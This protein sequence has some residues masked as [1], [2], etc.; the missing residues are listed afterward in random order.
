MERISLIPIG[1]IGSVTKNMYLYEYGDEILIVDCGL[2]FVD[3]TVPGVDLLL[4]DISYLKQT[5]KRIV[6]MV[7]THGHEDHIGALPF[8]LP[9]LPRFPVYGSTLTA[10][11]ANEKLKDFGSSHQVVPVSFGEEIRLGS[12]SIYWIRV[13][14]SILDT[15]HFFIRTPAGNFYHGSDFKFDFTPVDGKPSQIDSIVEKAQEGIVCLLSDCLGAEREGFSPSEMSIFESFEEEFRKT[16][17]KIFVTTYSSNISRLNQAIEVGVRLGRKICFIGRSLLKA[18]DVGKTLSYMKYP[19]SDEIKPHEVS[20]Y[21]PSQ[22]LLLVA[23]SQAQEDS[24]LVRIAQGEDRDVKIEKG[25][26]VI[27]SADPIPGNEVS[28]NSLIDT[29]AKAGA[30]VVYSAITD[31]FHVSGH[32]SQ[33]DLKLMISLTRPSSLLPIGGT[34]KQMVSFADIA[35][36]MGYQDK[37]VILIDNGQEVIFERGTWRT[38]RKIHMAH[39]FVDEITGGEMEHYIIRDRMKIAKDGM[40]VIIVEVDSSNGHIVGRPDIISRGFVYPKESLFLKKLLLTLQASF[41]K[42]KDNPQNWVYYKKIIQQHAEELLWK[43][44]RQPLVIPIVI[45]V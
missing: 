23:G 5:Q 31:E 27:F 7:L 20:R 11:L 34:Y 29:I 36:S 45:E 28:I 30:K 21:K 3:E 9:H 6:G 12:F 41:K 24:A 44:K 1:G 38:G 18:R 26:T 10:A 35:R 17:G 39:V 16:S 40:I 14:H 4:P 8:I 33:S 42:S 13:T 19:A 22:V 15:S 25:D 43:E 2:G 37:D 32:G